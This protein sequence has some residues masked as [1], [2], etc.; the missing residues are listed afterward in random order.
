[1]VKTFVYSLNPPLYGKIGDVSAYPLAHQKMMVLHKHSS[2]SYSS[3]AII[4]QC[5]SAVCHYES[6]MHTRY[7]S[8]I[9]DFPTKNILSITLIRW[10]V[11]RVLYSRTTLIQ[12]KSSS[13]TTFYSVFWLTTKYSIFSSL[14][15]VKLR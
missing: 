5:S 8:L 2:P 11:W 1:M 15:L 13:S 3:K 10:S 4:F 14:K 6:F 12:E 7:F 9:S